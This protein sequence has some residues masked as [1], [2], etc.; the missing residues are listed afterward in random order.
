[1]HSFLI[2]SLYAQFFNCF[3]ERKPSEKLEE[4]FDTQYTDK[5]KNRAKNV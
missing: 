4:K 3:K 5:K 2:I 1:M